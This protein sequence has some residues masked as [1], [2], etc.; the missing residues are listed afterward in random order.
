[1]PWKVTYY[2]E[3]VE[4]LVLSLPD[5]L[6]ARYARLTETMKGHGPHL[7]MPHTRA[8]GDGLFEL[9]LIGKEGI[10]RIFY[11]TVMRYEILMLHVFV[12]KTQKTPKQALAIARKRLKEVK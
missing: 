3:L 9:R 10:A 7:G 2:N 8:M 1:M 5:T 12:K 11:C 6:L 4:D